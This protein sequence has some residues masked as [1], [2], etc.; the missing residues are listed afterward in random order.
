LDQVLA[1]QAQ[2]VDTN[3]SPI[4]TIV[5]PTLHGESKLD[6]LA[7]EYVALL[8][9]K[10]L[11]HVVP[12][13]FALF[14]LIGLIGVAVHMLVLWS[15]LIF[16][17][18]GFGVAQSTATFVAMTSNFFLN[19]ILAFAGRPCKSAMGRRCRPRGRAA[20]NSST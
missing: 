4:V 9:D 7:W 16:L 17:S 18:W 2:A 14:G 6:T 20:I 15:G 11:G 8:A 1:T 12:V 19:N 13:R 3:A 5:V 10:L